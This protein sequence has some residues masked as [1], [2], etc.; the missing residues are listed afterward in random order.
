IEAFA[1]AATVAKRAAV[2]MVLN[3][4][5]V[6]SV[7][8]C[9]SGVVAVLRWCSYDTKNKCCKDSYGVAMWVSRKSL[10]INDSIFRV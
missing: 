2:M 6:L 10:R 1:V 4:V 8:C 9:V 7:W 5:L 3:I